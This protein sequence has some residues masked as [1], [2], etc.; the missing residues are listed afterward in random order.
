MMLVVCALS[1]VTHIGIISKNQTKYILLFNE[2]VLGT[3]IQGSRT[4]SS[5]FKL[6]NKFRS[7]S[8][9]TFRSFEIGL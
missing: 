4:R 3:A 2:H 1:Y 7:G 5:G 6:L 8:N 9:S